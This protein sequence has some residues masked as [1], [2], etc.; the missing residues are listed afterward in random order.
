MKHIISACFCYT[1]KFPQEYYNHRITMRINRKEDFKK[2][3]QLIS[4]M[5]NLNFEINEE[6]KVVTFQ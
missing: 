2:L 6:L 3:I 5:Y 1:L 4:E